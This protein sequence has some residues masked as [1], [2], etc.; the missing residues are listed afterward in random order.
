MQRTQKLRRIAGKKVTQSNYKDGV[1]DYLNPAPPENERRIMKN[2][3]Y[4][5]VFLH[6]C[7]FLSAF[8]RCGARALTM[9]QASTMRHFEDIVGHEKAKRYW[10]C[11]ALYAD[12]GRVLA[13]KDFARRGAGECL[14]AQ[15]LIDRCSSLPENSADERKVKAS[16]ALYI[17][18]HPCTV[19]GGKKNIDPGPAPSPEKLRTTIKLGGQ[20]PQKNGG[21]Q[22]FFDRHVALAD[23]CSTLSD[24]YDQFT[25]SNDKN[26]YARLEEAFQKYR[27][28]SNCVRTE[29]AKLYKAQKASD[30]EPAITF[31]CTDPIFESMVENVLK[32]G[33]SQFKN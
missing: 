3:S 13:D 10:Q 9:E 6:M 14:Q 1:Q 32:S 22:E 31:F 33:M 2:A 20:E 18:A 17:E 11:K 23:G 29:F 25:K 28:A 27:D 15:S 7:V 19:T 12:V 21:R 26:N 16:V 8:H 24:A 4:A 30:E 5:L